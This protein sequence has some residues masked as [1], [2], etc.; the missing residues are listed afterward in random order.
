[1]SEE[2]TA[3][4]AE[5]E[6]NTAEEKIHN[7]SV[8]EFM[9]RRVGG[10]V[11]EKSE[12]LPPESSE[13]SGEATEVAETQSEENVLSQL[14]IDN[15]SEA[16]LKELSEKLGSR[17]VARFGEMTA[18]RKAAEERAAQLEAT[19]KNQQS[20]ETYAPEVK[21]NPFSDLE[22]IQ[23]VQ[24]KMQEVTSTIEW[25]EEVLFESDSYSADDVVTEIDGKDL[26]KKEVRKALLN[27]RKA[28]NKFLPDQLNKV[29]ARSKGAELQVTFDNKAR[30]ELKW[31]N[32]EGPLRTQFANIVQDARYKKL[33]NYLN[34]EAPDLSSQLEYWFAH[35][36]NS[37]YGRQPIDTEP[38]KKAT[39]KARPSLNPTKTGSSSATKSEKPTNKTKKVLADLQARFAKT[40]SARDFAEMRKIQIQ[41]R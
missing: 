29:N 14:D 26:T 17:A 16:E 7:T 2:N 27:A 31:L 12:A 20:Q 3:A 5:A 4:V 21:N 34:K 6:Q 32:E 22:T 23:D 28:Q 8:E 11:E 40:G 19:L 24:T 18:R 41:N 13:E 1:M 30:Q 36:T 39:T 10:E 37:M 9:Q 35:A 33:K 25:A 15:L 38:V